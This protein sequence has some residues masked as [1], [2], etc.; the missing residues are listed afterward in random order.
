MVKLKDFE[1]EKIEFNCPICNQEYSQ[2]IKAK[3]IISSNFTDFIKIGDYICS[4]CAK[5]F[6]LYFYS[7]IVNS[8]GIKLLNVRQIKDELCSTQKVPFRFVITTSQK[9]H[10]FYHSK[11]NYSAER[12]AVNLETETIYTT[13]KRMLELFDFVESLI[14]IGASKKS[15][16]NGEIPFCVLQKTGFKALEYL[17]TELKKSREIQIPL[18][19]GQ[20]LKKTEEECL[21]SLD[22]LLNQKKEAK[23]P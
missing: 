2:G 19:C 21:C 14:T 18:Y 6:S 3:K 4:D 9:K 13:K 12:F 17:Q 1:I 20:K 22:L 15:M 8:D 16:Q 10:L 5:L 23:Q 11:I 7:Y